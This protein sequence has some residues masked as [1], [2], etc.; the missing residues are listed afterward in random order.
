[1]KSAIIPMVKSHQ[2]LYMYIIVSSF[3]IHRYSAHIHEWSIEASFCVH[4]VQASLHIHRYS[5]RI[6]ECSI[7]VHLVCTYSTHACFIVASL[8]VHISINQSINMCMAPKGW[9]CFHKIP[10]CTL[11]TL[12][13]Y[14]HIHEGIINTSL[15]ITCTY[16]CTLLEN[17]CTCVH[18]IMKY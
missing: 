8:V 15:Y 6:H 4:T 2:Q 3:C 7:K 9:D 14:I 16:I 11:Y 5:T 13:T 18:T 1:M 10:M 17:P 12:C